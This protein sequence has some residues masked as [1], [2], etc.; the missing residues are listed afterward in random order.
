MAR[1]LHIGNQSVPLT[2]DKRSSPALA[3]RIENTVW[4]GT[5]A[6]G[7]APGR[8]TLRMPPAGQWAGEVYS[9][10]EPGGCPAG[11]FC[12][13]IWDD[14][15]QVWT[16]SPE[17]RNTHPTWGGTTVWWDTSWYNSNTTALTNHGIYPTYY[18]QMTCSTTTGSYAVRGN[19]V[20][21]TL[22]FGGTTRQC[23]CRLKSRADSAAGG[24]VFLTSYSS[25][26]DCA[27]CP[28]QCADNAGGASVF[29]AAL[30][31]AFANP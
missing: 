9:L 6:S 31:N 20:M 23:W 5:L 26:A 3:V 2:S 14:F 16:W 11:Y 12:S 17:F 15:P 8:L 10:I 25:A 4:Y 21:P 28:V 24:W 1:T 19:P 18:I 13:T 22:P 30:L 27:H 7:T 29:R